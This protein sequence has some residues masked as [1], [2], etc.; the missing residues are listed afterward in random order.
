MA[1][2]WT[3]MFPPKPVWTEKDIPD[4][5]GRVFIITGGSAGIGYEVAKALFHVNAH[6]FIA[7]RSKE[8]AEKAVASITASLPSSIQKVK[9]GKGRIEFLPLDLGDLSTIRSTVEAFSTKAS[10]L[11]VVWHNAGVMYPADNTPT[12]QGYHVQLGINGLGTWLFQHYL[13]PICLKTAV[14]IVQTTPITHKQKLT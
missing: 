5:Q 14:S 8:G 13:T 10:R 1:A 3:E 12:T 7:S 4:Q 6:V 11:D 9:A 2:S